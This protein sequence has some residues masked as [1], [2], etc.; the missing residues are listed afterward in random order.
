MS[1]D[2]RRTYNDGFPLPPGYVL[3][4]DAHHRVLTEIRDALRALVLATTYA[5]D[6]PSK[7]TTKRHIANSIAE[8]IDFDRIPSPAPGEKASEG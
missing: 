8:L 6:G 4:L 5:A 2:D 3:D 7:P 1:E